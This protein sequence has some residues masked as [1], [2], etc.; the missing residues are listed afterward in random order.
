MEKNY[1]KKIPGLNNHN[2]FAKIIK[3]LFHD[4]FAFDGC[5]YEK[6]EDC[7]VEITSSKFKKT[8]FK[9]DGEFEKYI[10]VK[11]ILIRILKNWKDYFQFTKVYLYTQ[12]Q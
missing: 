5:W 3:N 8:V 10:L 9:K 7:W 2:G 1:Q 11:L 6:S 4:D 12:V